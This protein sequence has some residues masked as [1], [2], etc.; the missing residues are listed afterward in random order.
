MKS[1]VTY[2]K[3][4]KFEGKKH[5]EACISDVHLPAIAAVLKLRQIGS[6]LIKLK[7]I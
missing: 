1:K 7:N 4:H 2:K 3:K 5:M 6:C